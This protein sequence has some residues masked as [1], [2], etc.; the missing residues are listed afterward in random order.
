MPRRLERRVVRRPRCAPGPVVTRDCRA[1]LTA[2]QPCPEDL[3]SRSHDRACSHHV[4]WGSPG[5]FDREWVRVLLRRPAFVATIAAVVVAVVA[6][7]LAWNLGR[8]T[9][10]IAAHAS[11]A[12]RT[13]SPV[14]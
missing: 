13:D 11:N 12:S 9:E 14:S 6:G 10:G 2:E 8:L 1:R 3:V 4:M 7:G 5:M